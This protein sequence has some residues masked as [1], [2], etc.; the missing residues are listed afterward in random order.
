MQRVS[1][2]R[3]RPRLCDAEVLLFDKV[4]HMRAINQNMSRERV[5]LAAIEVCRTDLLNH[6]LIASDRWLAAFMA[7][8]GLTVRRTM[9]LVMLTG[10]EHA[11]RA[12]SFV[13]YLSSKLPVVD[14]TAML[15]MDETAVYFEDPQNTTNGFPGARHVIRRSIGIAS[16]HVTA[17]LAVTAAGAEVALLRIWKGAA[18]SV[19]HVGG[20][21]MAQHPKAW[22]NIELLIKWI[23]IMY[24]DLMNT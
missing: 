19:K 14:P 24:P 7:Q 1:G 5:K 6:T 4:M 16:M 20:V 3:A 12:I 22:V 23:N 15:L 11:G 18:Q 21:Y 8:Y 10:A 2:A 9:N 13:G 17:A